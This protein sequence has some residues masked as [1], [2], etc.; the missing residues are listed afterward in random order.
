MGKDKSKDSFLKGALILGIAGVAVKII[1]AFFRIPLGNMIGSTGM[2]YYQSA[3][4]VYTL[5]LTLATAGFPT[6]V[7]KLVSEKI[8]IGDDRGAHKIFKVSAKVLF[9]TGI[10]SFCI[11]FFGAELIVNGFIKNPGALSSMRAIAPALIIVPLMSAYRGYFQGQKDMSKIAISQIVEQLFRVVLGLALAFMLMRSSGPTM[12]AAGA[13][14]GAAIGALGSIIY[15]L[16]AYLRG[17]KER[18]ERLSTAKHFEEE[19]F[20][21]ILK[22]LLAVAIPITIGASVMPLVNMVD[23][24]I[25][26]RRLMVAGFSLKEANSMFGQLTGMAM[27][28]I[29]LPAVITTAMSMSLV[30][31]ISQSYALGNK[32]AAR[33]D[34]QKAVKVTLIIVLPCAFGMAS[35]AGPIMNLLYPSEPSIVGTILFTLTPCVIFLGIIQTLTGIL[36]GMGKPMVPVIALMVG[37]AFKI[38]ISYTLTA[39]PSINVLGSAIGTVT[40]YTVAALVN[41]IYVKKKMNVTFPSREFVIKPLFTVISMFAAVKLSYMLIAMFT[42][43]AIATLLSIVV[44]AAVYAVVLLGVGGI[45]KDEIMTLP[46]GAKIYALLKKCKLVR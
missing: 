4:P 22:N 34:T 41:F 1:G 13:I 43:N 14:S 16:M 24:G 27:S 45:T 26:I 19:Q 28:I 29:N 7:A 32:D 2:G 20:S 23:N 21:L 38:G 18:K 46:K 5:F 6:A 3:Y 42:G 9:I 40:A 30:P 44:G 11:F 33:K 36:Q 25:V 39:I 15:L 17:S 8:A 35:L 12:G 37:M 10:V 31:S